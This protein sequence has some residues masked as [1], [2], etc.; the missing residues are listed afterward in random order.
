MCVCRGDRNTRQ[1]SK[2]E[3]LG[4]RRG[5]EIGVNLGG[6]KGQNWGE[7]DKNALY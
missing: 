7:Y 6:A 2:G 5:E 4:E 1:T 3:Y